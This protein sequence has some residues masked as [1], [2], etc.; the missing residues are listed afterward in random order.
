M[1]GLQYEYGFGGIEEILNG[2]VKKVDSQEE[3]DISS[4]GLIMIPKLIGIYQSG[5]K[6]HQLEEV[7]EIEEEINQIIV[8]CKKGES[9]SASPN[10]ICIAYD[11]TIMPKDISTKAL[12]GDILGRIKVIEHYN[13]PDF[14]EKN[15]PKNIYD[16]LRR[17]MIKPTSQNLA[18]AERGRDIL[19]MLRSDYGL[20]RSESIDLFIAEFFISKL[21]GSPCIEVPKSMLDLAEEIIDIT[22]YLDS[23]ED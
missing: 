9:D 10:L 15:P 23:K 8:L 4:P 14:H 22:R 7:E 6:Y 11:S 12:E 16:T 2:D 18:V 19:R 13:L 1:N 3:L 17:I 5:R 21:G 20:T